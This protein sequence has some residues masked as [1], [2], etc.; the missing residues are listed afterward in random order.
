MLRAPDLLRLLD[1]FDPGADSSAAGSVELTRVLLRQSPDPFSRSSFQPGHITASGIVLS[2]DHEQVL[3]VFHRR[4]KRWLQPGGHVEPS[5]QDLIAAA[6]RE[7]L[8][9]T[10]AGLDPRAHPVLVGVDVHRI[11]ARSD[12]PPHLHH[13]FVFRF[14]AQGDRLVAE[15]GREVRWCGV[16][17][18]G[19]YDADGALRRSVARA[20]GVKG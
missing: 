14:V 20:T 12:E 9:E 13:D 15:V 10:G 19:D 4:L 17:R 6:R 2:P 18:L 1:E 5:D 8:E 7:I 3:L 11:P 16:N